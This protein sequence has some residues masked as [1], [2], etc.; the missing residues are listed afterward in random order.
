MLTLWKSTIASVF[1]VLICAPSGF[2]QH[3]SGSRGSQGGSASQGVTLLVNVRDPSGVPMD[4]V[5]VVTLVA[6]VGSY[7]RTVTTRDASTAVFDGLVQGEYDAEASYPGYKTTTDHISVTALGSTMQVYLYLQLESDKKSQG[8]TLQGIVMSPKLQA[9]IDKGMEALRKSEFETAR[10]HFAKGLAMAPGNPDLSYFLGTAELGLNHPDIARQ[11]FEHALAIDPTHER[12]LLALGELQL[13]NG[14]ISAAIAT[15]E[16]AFL[17]N[18]ASWRTQLLL[19]SAYAKAGRLPDAEAHAQRAAELAPDKGA[20]ARLLLGEIQQAEGK[21]T[22]AENTFKELAAK[23]PNDPS[24]EQVKKRLASLSAPSPDAAPPKPAELAALPVPTLPRIELLPANERPWAPLDIDSREF[25]LAQNASCNA[26]EI[27]PHAQHRLNLQLKNFEKFTATEHIDHQEIDRLGRPGPVK[28]RD[29]SYIVFVHS[30]AGDSFFLEEDRYSTGK[31]NSFPTSLAT[32]G[33]NNLGVS[34]LQPA[35]RGEFVYQCEGVAAIRGKAA[36]QIRFQEK[37]ESAGSIRDWRHD[38][39]L[40][41][42][43]I[44]GRIWLASASFDVLRIETDLLQPVQTLGL[45]RDHLLVDYGPVNFSAANTTL[46][47]P[48]SAEMHMELHGHR[49]HHKH[50]LT[51]YM[52]FEVDTSHKIGKPKNPPLPPPTTQATPVGEP[53]SL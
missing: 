31:D 2:G 32:T 27:L 42:V 41:P 4:G 29:F 9:E 39:K 53:N 26:E 11:N 52:L 13:R 47:L 15:L 21:M 35:T 14:E 37:K 25:P 30:Y 16:K 43:P 5:T 36:W 22:E 17:R 44:K 51:D 7:H 33:L 23:F 12:S 28:S 34:I 48:W 6:T 8:P 24:A 45:T 40:Y 18:G 3:P 20:G 38:G 49:Y 10:V 19:A 46:W 50:Y 1:I